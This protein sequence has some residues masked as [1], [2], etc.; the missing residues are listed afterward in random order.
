MFTDISIS[1]NRSLRRFAFA[2]ICIVMGFF[3]GMQ[4]EVFSVLHHAVP[5]C[6]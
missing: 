4:W 3:L 5:T 6:R 2:L 1:A